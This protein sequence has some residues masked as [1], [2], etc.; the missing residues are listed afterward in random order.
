MHRDAF[1]RFYANL[2]I[3]IRREVVLVLDEQGPITWEVAYK[4]IKENTELGKIILQK[5]VELK[6]IPVE[7]KQK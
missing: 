6:F 2:P 7:D 4:E 5:L 1:F 3:G